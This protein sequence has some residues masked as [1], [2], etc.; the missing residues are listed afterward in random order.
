MNQTSFPE[1]FKALMIFPVLF[2]SN[3]II[4]L[5][6]VQKRKCLNH[7]NSNCTFLGSYFTVV[8]LLSFITVLLLRNSLS[9]TETFFFLMFSGMNNPQSP[10]L[11]F[12][13][14]GTIVG[15]PSRKYP[16][17]EKIGMSIEPDLLV[18]KLKILWRCILGYKREVTD[19]S[20]HWF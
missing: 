5:D 16:L 18:K 14:S 13:T 12:Q 7:L 9:N 15:S 2:C 20:S 10:T 6:I 3:V 8:L 19:N 11:R 1:W 4:I 17:G